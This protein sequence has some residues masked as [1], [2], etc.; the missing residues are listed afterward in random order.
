MLAS[1]QKI[2][3]VRDAK[4]SD[5]LELVEVLGWQCVIKKGKHYPGEQIVFIE[6]DSI[7]PDWPE[8]AFLKGNN[9]I[10]TVKLRGNISQGLIMSIK[11]YYTV[12]LH[13]VYRV[14]FDLTGALKIQKYEKPTPNCQDAAGPFPDFITKTDEVNVQSEPGLIEELKGHQ[15]YVTQK[16]DGCSCTIY[17][18]GGHFGV[19][20]RNMEI[21]RFHNIYWDV[22]EKY[23]LENIFSKYDSIAIQGEIA[24]PGIQKNPMGLKENELRIFNMWDIE[25]GEYYNYL[26]LRSFT[27]RYYLQMVPI[28]ESLTNWSPSIGDLI[29]LAKLEKYPNGKPAEG[30]VIRPI[31]NVFSEI[32]MKRL[33]FKVL[34]P[35]YKD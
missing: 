4:N 18:K 16:V 17:Q 14:G 1:I 24:G 28:I 29:E 8:Y 22:A 21:K 6:I 32:L 33:S 9:R 25:K 11:D 20:S 15:C 34:N 13:D 35:E 23:D 26:Q 7:V 30:I 31:E 12:I 10:K 2:K 19:C 5:S 27:A 3:S